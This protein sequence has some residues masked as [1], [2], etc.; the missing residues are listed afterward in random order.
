ME[1]WAHWKEQPLL[2]DKLVTLQLSW[3]DYKERDTKYFQVQ[4][5]EQTDWTCYHKHDQWVTSWTHNDSVPGI[6]TCIKAPKDYTNNYL[7]AEVLLVLQKL[8]YATFILK[9]G[10]KIKS[11]SCQKT[12]GNSSINWLEIANSLATITDLRVKHAKEHAIMKIPPPSTHPK[13][14]EQVSGASFSPRFSSKMKNHL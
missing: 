8:P 5:A 14:P 11:Q 10:F 2:W 12:E 3:T 1:K 7:A 4:T 9:K 13:K 6:H